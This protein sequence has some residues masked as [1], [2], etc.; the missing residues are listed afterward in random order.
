[1]ATFVVL[2]GFTD[3]GIRNVKET[4]GRAEAFKEM[5]EKSGITVKDLYWTLGQ[6]DVIAVCEG[7][8][9]EAATALSGFCRYRAIASGKMTNAHPK[10]VV[11]LIA[12]ATEIVCA[13]GARDLRVGRSHECDFH[14]RPSSA[15]PAATP[16]RTFPLIS[17]RPAGRLRGHIS[18]CM[19]R[20]VSARF[21]WR[22]LPNTPILTTKRSGILP[23]GGPYS[24]SGKQ[25]SSRAM[26][27][28]GASKPAGNSPSAD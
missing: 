10:R 24:P 23:S 12:S 4:I 20:N 17:G 25:V 1:M 28:A 7:P 11:S 3:Q 18:A 14:T 2:A 9:D 5:A 27:S 15:S 19:A 13:I 26:T 8:D 22:G 21:I 6:Y 16:H